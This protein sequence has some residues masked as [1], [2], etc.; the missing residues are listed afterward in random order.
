MR[1]LCIRLRRKKAKHLRSMGAQGLA[2]VSVINRPFVS[3][4]LPAA[5]ACWYSAASSNAQVK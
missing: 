3:Y 5:P 1:G 4:Y 2:E